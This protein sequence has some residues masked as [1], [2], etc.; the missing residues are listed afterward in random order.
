MIRSFTGKTDATF[1]SFIWY[2][3]KKTPFSVEENIQNTNHIHKA[4]SEQHELK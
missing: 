4:L 1:S 2:L 3:I